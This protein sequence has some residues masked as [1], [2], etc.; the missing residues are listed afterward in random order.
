MSLGLVNKTNSQVY[1]I[2]LYETTVPRYIPIEIS[3]IGTTSVKDP[4]S[5]FSKG[6]IHPFERYNTF[7][8]ATGGKGGIAS[9]AKVLTI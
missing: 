1:P 9:K 8:D 7:C 6:L 4:T 2:Q 5:T 3:S